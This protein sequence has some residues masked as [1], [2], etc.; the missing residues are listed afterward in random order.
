VSATKKKLKN[1]F[2]FSFYFRVHT[3]DNKHKPKS[4][5]KKSENFYFLFDKQ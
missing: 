3:L 1:I 5:P 4:L 2:T